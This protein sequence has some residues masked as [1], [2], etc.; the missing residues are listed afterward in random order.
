M[1][2]FSVQSAYEEEDGRAFVLKGTPYGIVHPGYF[3]KIPLIGGRKNDELAIGGI[4]SDPEDGDHVIE[5]HFRT[6]KR[7]IE[8]LRGVDFVGETFQI[9]EDE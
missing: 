9:D 8:E 4:S 7:L 3:L 6:T 5:L 1:I 2:N